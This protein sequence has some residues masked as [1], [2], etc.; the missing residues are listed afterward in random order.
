MS[1]PA[2]LALATLL[3]TAA[4]AAARTL[5]WESIEVEARLH[6]DG[7][8][9][10]LERQLI[11]FSGDWNGGQ[12]AFRVLPGQELRLHGMRRIDPESGERVVMRAGNLAQVDNYD[13]QGRDVLRWRS[14]RPSDPEFDA[15]AI[16]YELDYTLIGVVQERDGVYWVDHDFAPLDRAGRI[17]RLHLALRIDEPWSALPI[18]GVERGRDSGSELITLTR[19]GLLPGGLVVVNF[20]LERT[21][22]TPAEA[23][24]RLLPR[25]WR[26]AIVAALL[27]V[28]ALL[29]LR[30]FAHERAQGRYESATVPRRPDPDWLAEHLL[31]MKPEIV[32]AVWDRRIGSAEVAAVLA[33]LVAEGRLSSSVRTEGRWFKR[34]IL[35]LEL[36]VD[37]DQLSSYERRLIDRLFFGGRRQTD[38]AAVRERYRS[39]GFSPAA[40]IRSGIEKE[41]R[42]LPGFRSGLPRPSPAVSML[43]TLAGLSCLTVEAVTR[44]LEAAGPIVA[45]MLVVLAP[46]LVLGQV[47]ARWHA[48]RADRLWVPAALLI[49]L[50]T[51]CLAVSSRTILAGSEFILSGIDYAG[52][53]GR[54][55]L[56][57]MTLALVNSVLNAARTRD[58]ADAV[59]LRRRLVALRRS[60]ARELGEHRPRLDD[61]WYPYLLALGLEKKVDRWFEAF[62]GVSGASSAGSWSASTS[63]SGGGASRWTG[64]GGA[65][66]GGGA[67]SSWAAAA[68]GLAAGVSRPGSGGSSGGGS[69]SSGGGGGSGGGGSGGW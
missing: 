35:E 18:P 22:G 20:G 37:R 30:L 60:L 33:R 42:R 54:L 29:L 62:G 26:L 39:S 27:A 24:R 47:F 56:A 67:S 44:G 2:R 59:R 68:G 51:A 15:T 31:G 45:L 13:W 63:S 14:R 19:R 32:G 3:L 36:L 7:R 38:T 49:L 34:R 23:V 52:L 25:S 5:F 6:G 21:D 69:S 40:T 1:I 46:A 50:L 66:G 4:P 53:F 8:L 58:R 43:L 12:R 65:F 57:L 28:A 48:R 17:E 11:V 41:L 64:G 55:G 61:A 16:L 9:R 10:V